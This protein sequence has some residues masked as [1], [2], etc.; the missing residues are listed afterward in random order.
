MGKND[1]FTH[2]KMNLS[3]ARKGLLDVRKNQIL[4][5]FLWS[6]TSKIEKINFKKRDKQ[7][8]IVSCRK[9]NM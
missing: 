5:T 8:T 1:T 2:K 9:R 6:T 3:V 7:T 4:V